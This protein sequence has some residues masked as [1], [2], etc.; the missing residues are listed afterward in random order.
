MTN[1]YSVPAVS[2]DHCKQ[3]I[4]GA[5]SKLEGVE[6]V[7]VDIDARSVRVD[8]PVPDD[9]VRSAI[10]DAGYEVAGVTSA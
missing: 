3:S 4:E 9:K 1:M 7:I 6:S 8:G 5:V 2:C 10:T